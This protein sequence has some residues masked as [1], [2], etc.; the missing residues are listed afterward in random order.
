MLVDGAAP[1]DGT[2]VPSGDAAALGCGSVDCNAQN[3][4]CCVYPIANPPPSFLAGCSN[5]ASCPALVSDAG[6]EAG[7]AAELHCEV[8]ANCTG[9][10]VCCLQA[11]STG[12]VNAHCKSA[13]ACVATVAD[14]G[15]DGG[16]AGSVGLPTAML[17]DP[18]LGG[19]AGCGDGGGWASGN[20]GS[21]GLPSGFGTCGGVHK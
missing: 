17:C 19:D 11:P 12:V 14:A 20:I 3:E 15:A 18:S 21:W 9:A 8:Q 16:E 5:G 2:T 4:T 10:T 7:A 1:L 6:Y 13:G